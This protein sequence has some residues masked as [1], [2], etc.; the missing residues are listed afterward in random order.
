MTAAQAIYL[1]LVGLYVLFFILFARLFWW[2]RYAEAKYWKRRPKLSLDGVNQMAADSGQEV[3]RFSVFV[4]AR[5][6]ADVIEKTINHLSRLEYPASQYEVL[7]VTDEK[8]LLAR[9]EEIDGAIEDAVDF[10][11]WGESRPQTANEGCQELVL[12]LLA[13]LSLEELGYLQ[14]HLG[15]HFPVREARSLP[16]D[17]QRTILRET[18]LD[19]V[20][21]KGRIRAGSVYSSIHRA[22]PGLSAE[23]ARRI[24]PVFLSLAMPVVVAFARL[25]KDAGD[26]MTGRMMAQT[27][28]ASQSV[29][30]K[31]LQTMTESISGRILERLI[32]LRK[33]DVLAAVLEEVYSECFPTTQDF[34]ERKQKEYAGRTDVP[35]LKHVVVPYDFDGNYGGVCTGKP[36]PSTKGRALNYAMR[37]ADPRSAMFGFYDAESRPDARVLLYVAYRRLQDG[38]KVGILQGPVFQ[39]RNFYKMGP[40]CKIVSL[41]QAISHDWAMPSLFK[42]LPFV[43][44][45]NLFID[46]K[47]ME[48]IKGFDHNCLTED[49]EL[50]ARAYLE[51]GVWPE[52]LPY[53]SSE[54]TPPTFKA[55]YRQRLRWGSGY[56]QV[57]DKIRDEAGYPEDK[58]RALLRTF[59]LKGHVEWTLYQSAALIPPVVWLLWSQGLLDAS[60][61][62]WL[63]SY[64]MRT[65]SIVYFL[66]TFYAY[67]RYSGHLD[68]INEP[69][70][71]LKRVGALSQ[72]L[73]LPISA[74][75]LPVPY[76]SALV[77]KALNKNPKY[78]V[79]T[80]RTRE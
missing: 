46:T 64:A 17:R 50:G 19:L 6:E 55:F 63:V 34:V 72:L 33:Q 18:V 68:E 66:F 2:K 15:N 35:K 16:V 13:R 7:V 79:K 38:G 77:L 69:W 75:F 52:Y 48:E 51:Q 78:W 80:P 61:A 22:L 25:K 11:S 57:V 30:Q 53:P 23:D 49:L 71:G 58:K 9:A 37:F 1:F 54:Q 36:V 41:Y 27:A 12:G 3:P 76:S 24:Y 73:L 65:L 39:V 67:F 45:T 74:F 31:I 47:L 32:R 40:L 62:P 59:Y 26:R 29:T 20:R 44:G 56:L 70:A 60:I 28:R 42:K 10:L 43:G 4:P 14:R 8:E 5:N 21:G